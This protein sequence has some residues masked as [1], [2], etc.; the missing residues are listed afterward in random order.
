MQIGKTTGLIAALCVMLLPALASCSGD[1]G[2]ATTSAPTST[3][4]APV[5]TTTQTPD[6]GTVF[7]PDA[8]ALWLADPTGAGILRI[9]AI[10]PDETTGTEVGFAPS[11]LAVAEGLVWVGGEASI[12]ALD[13]STTAVVGTIAT[14]GPTTRLVGTSSGVW[15][16]S[17]DSARAIHSDDFT[18]GSPSAVN[19]PVDG[20]ATDTDLWVL[21]INDLVQIDLASEERVTSYEISLSDPAAIREGVDSLLLFGRDGTILRIDSATGDVINE[22]QTAVS[23]VAPA[24]VIADG[25]DYW[26]VDESGQLIQLD[27]DLN[28]GVTIEI[29]IPLTAVVGTSDALWVAGSE[30]LVRVTR[31]EYQVLQFPLS[32]TPAAIAA[33]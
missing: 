7:N 1:D 18:L 8:E 32:F 13:P 25:P 12:A 9:D 6:T 26:V 31:D 29:G 5:A 14:D 11:A 27:A 33:S 22:A 30:A 10:D 23:A 21:G 24:G 20:V 16:L 3:T 19:A 17:E 28:E 15:V 4:T 2:E